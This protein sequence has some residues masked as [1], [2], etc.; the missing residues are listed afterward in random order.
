MQNLISVTNLS[1]SFGNVKVLNNISFNI[2][3][4]KIYGLIGHN[5]AGK[6]TILNSILGLLIMKVK[7]AF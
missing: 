3:K 7:L 2:E 6:T 4:G 1:K 5:G